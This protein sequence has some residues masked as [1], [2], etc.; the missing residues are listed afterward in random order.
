MFAFVTGTGEARALLAP[1]VRVFRNEWGRG[2]QQGLTSRALVPHHATVDFWL[3]VKLQSQAVIMYTL[4]NLGLVIGCRPDPLKDCNRVFR[5]SRQILYLA[6]LGGLQGS[7]PFVANAT[8]NPVASAWSAGGRIFGS[9]SI[10]SHDHSF[11]RE[12]L[13]PSDIWHWLHTKIL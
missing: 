2:E 9:L 7:V 1:C 6:C 11:E 5:C 3:G 8:I 12:C 10:E 4:K 13:T